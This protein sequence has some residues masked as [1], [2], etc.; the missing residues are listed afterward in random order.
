MDN[1]VST[2][3][4]KTKHQIYFIKKPFMSLL[5]GS[6]RFG[7]ALMLGA[8]IITLTACNDD[9]EKPQSEEPQKTCSKHQGCSETS[10]AKA[11]PSNTSA[12]KLK[13]SKEPLEAITL[14][15]DYSR[16]DIYTPYELTADLSHLSDKQKK[17]LSLFIDAA[18]IMDDL[19]WQQAFGNKEM[20][21]TGLPDE[22]TKKFVEINYGPWDRLDGNKPFVHAYKEKSL[23]AMFYPEDMSKQEF[24]QWN[25]KNKK[26][27]YSIVRRLDLE[28]LEVIP[29]SIA[30]YEE[31]HEARRLILKASLLAEDK[32]FKEY[33]QILAE[34]LVSDY[35]RGSDMLW[36]DMKNNKIDLVYG[37]IETYEDKLFGYR[38]AFSAY[39]LVKDLAWSEKL[40]KFA[41]FLPELQKNLPVAKKYKQEMPG[42][43]SQ[44]NAYDVIYYAGD[45]NAGS[46][47]IAINLPN[48]ELVQKEKGSRR[49]Q[50]K[51]AMRAKFDKILLPLSEVLIDPKQRQN[52]TF[53]AFFENTMFHEVAHG[54]GIKNT[55]NGKG[56]VRT[57]LK[58]TASALEEGKADIL[59]LYMVIELSK[60]GEIESKNLMDNYVTFLASIFRSVRFGASSAHGKANM[61][62][63][64]YFKQAGAFKR[65]EK[66][67]YYSVDFD[68]MTQ[69]INSLSEKILTIQGEGDYTA[70]KTLL[71]KQGIISETLA[72]D[73]KRLEKAQIP[74][75]IDFIQGKEVLGLK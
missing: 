55:V 2:R 58:E 64:N 35:Y 11:S 13:T 27:M 52:I 4:Q 28:N 34:S 47:T 9:N 50:L 21:L 26:N 70:A 74:V 61:V 63:F 19:F 53:N 25:D 41:L 38:A 54:L 18:D 40:E 66:T 43:N 36:M 3:L 56:L 65:D 69:A 51:N 46:K 71:E 7:F 12:N 14:K 62:R 48:D 1:R 16:Y 6:K 42:T 73:L 31:L 67:G 30:Y 60:K 57:A 44:L 49:L 29:Y 22:K 17:M 10:E 59:G 32:Q 37:P 39:V 23:G 15:E 75:D 45:S 33:L 68:K 24:E 5:D 72:A 20:L 8:S